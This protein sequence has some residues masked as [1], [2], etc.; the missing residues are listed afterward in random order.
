[1]IE[2]TFH[3]GERELHAARATVSAALEQQGVSRT[4]NDDVVSVVNE[5]VA[6]ARECG[7]TAPLAVTVVVYP[8][9]TSVR[10][11]CDRNVELRDKPFDV[12]ERLIHRLAIA[13]GRRRREDGSVDLWAEIARPRAPLGGAASLGTPAG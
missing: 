3:A 6:A 13:S 7:L 11:R 12:R 9:L 4:H 2:R 1:V 10:V 5:L 8:L